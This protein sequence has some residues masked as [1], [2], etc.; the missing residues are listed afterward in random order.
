MKDVVKTIDEVRSMKGKLIS[1]ID[2]NVIGNISHAR[3][4][5]TEFAKLNRYWVGCASIN[6]MDNPEM[7]DLF[8]KS[9][10]K[11]LLVG[12]ESVNQASLNAANKGFSQVADYKRIIAKLHRHGIMVQGTFVLGFD[13]D[14]KTT[15]ENTAQFII[16]AK[17][18]LAQITIYTPF[19]GTAAFRRIE[20][21]GRLLT[22]DWNLYN[23]QNV[24]FKP[25]QMTPEELRQ[26]LAL[27][28]KRV[29]GYR[30]IAKR[31]MGPPYL[32][33]APIAFSNLSYPDT[34]ARQPRVE[35]TPELVS[36]VIDEIA[37]W[38]ID[39]NHCGT[40]VFTLQNEPLLDVRLPDFV[41]ETRRK[42]ALRWDIEITTIGVL[43]CGDM[44]RR[45]ADAEP[46]VVNVS[47]NG[48]TQ[49]TYDAEFG[50][51]KRYWTARGVAVIG[52]GCNDRLG[53]VKDYE[54]M[55]SRTTGAFGEFLRKRIGGRIFSVCPF[56]FCQANILPSGRVLMCC[57][58]YRHEAIL[59]TLEQ[60][61]GPD[62]APLEA[63]VRSLAQIFNS[64]EAWR[65]RREAHKGTYSGICL[66]CSLF[67]SHVWL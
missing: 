6:L 16:D 1:F 56:L 47:V 54:S 40:L 31:L 20:S 9:G 15:F 55:R 33:K 2:P 3:A 43:L 32:L 36:R 18:D 13:T 59:G 8:V 24:V 64:D 44:A 14:D 35:I 50:A 7:L 21:E 29:Y 17:I 12:F 46:R 19:P 23:G 42:L 48:F 60:P 25:A 53:D 67:K 11:G 63:G 38:S 34:V 45:L 66:R 52:Y 58:D 28:W 61:L 57:H 62:G 51:L 27:V 37:S 41:A 49:A 5:F 39:R 30:A 26:G 22:R 65:L 10:C 4:F